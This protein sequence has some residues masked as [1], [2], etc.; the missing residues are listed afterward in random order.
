MPDLLSG[1]AVNLTVL[2]DGVRT[3]SAR[4]T[5]SILKHERLLAEI[6][7]ADVLSTE[8][9]KKLPAEALYFVIAGD[10]VIEEDDGAGIIVTAGDVILMPAEVA[11]RFVRVSSKFRTWRIWLRST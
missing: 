3:D 4:G 8:P 9:S 11:H 2:A 1:R 10:S 5:Q 7:G 6:A